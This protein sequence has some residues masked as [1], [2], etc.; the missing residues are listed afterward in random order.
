[1][2]LPIDLDPVKILP[3][4]CQ[5]NPMPIV[6]HHNSIQPNEPIQCEINCKYTKKKNDKKNIE[7]LAKHNLKKQQT[8]NQT[9]EKRSNALLF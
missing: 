2:V 4:I 8:S 3:R 6:F 5:M 9:L 7:F 1:M